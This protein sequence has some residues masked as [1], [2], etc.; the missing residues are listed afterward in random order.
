M[1]D[2][3]PNGD[4]TRAGP[5]TAKPAEQPFA[6]ETLARKVQRRKQGVKLNED[7]PPSG[8]PIV[9]IEHVDYA[10]GTGRRVRVVLEPRAYGV[11]IA[12]EDPV[13]GKLLGEVYIENYDK[14][15]VYVYPVA[16]KPVQAAL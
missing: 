3:M 11:I 12:I 2:G 16:G 4:P 5:F 1:I 10:A 15:T 9:T 7:V 14:Q 6:A 8:L 13:T